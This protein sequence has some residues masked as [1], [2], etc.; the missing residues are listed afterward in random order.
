[1]SL[2]CYSYQSPRVVKSTQTCQLVIM[3]LL[4]N[5]SIVC[6]FRE[7]RISVL[8]TVA[9]F[10]FQRSQNQKLPRQPTCFGDRRQL[11][12]MT[13]I[14]YYWK[15]ESLV[16]LYDVQHQGFCLVSY[17]AVLDWRKCHREYLALASF[18][19]LP[20][21]R[22]QYFK[23]SKSGLI[24]RI[25]TSS[26]AVPLPL[27]TRTVEITSKTK[28]KTDIDVMQR[29][30]DRFT[31]HFLG[32]DMSRTDKIALDG[33]VKTPVDLNVIRIAGG[34]KILHI[35]MYHKCSVC[36]MK[37]TDFEVQE[38]IEEEWK[39]H[40]PK[41]L[42]QVSHVPVWRRGGDPMLSQTSTQE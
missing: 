28:A 41:S 24:H 30:D 8:L 13:D 9:C 3:E 4:S 42:P 12:G 11:A 38:A 16:F 27:S 25:V 32:I 26:L 1:M 33:T 39:C 35:L 36:G 37:I 23:C 2:E 40:G 34:L 15:K 18:L 20:P 7:N 22:F 14:E 10:F 31:H 17:S 21:F 5:T 19:V 29:H 6:K